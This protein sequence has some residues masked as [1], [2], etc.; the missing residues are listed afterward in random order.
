MCASTRPLRRHTSIQVAVF[1]NSIKTAHAPTTVSLSG[2]YR[3]PLNNSPPYQP[4]ISV[5]HIRP[6]AGHNY[7]AIKRWRGFDGTLF[8][9]L[10][11]SNC[12]SI[13]ESFLMEKYEKWYTPL[14]IFARSLSLSLINFFQVLSP[15]EICDSKRERREK[16]ISFYRKIALFRNRKVPLHLRYNK[17]LLFLYNYYYSSKYVCIRLIILNTWYRMRSSFSLNVMSVFLL[18]SSQEVLLWAS[19]DDQIAFN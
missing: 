18:R 17:N 7:L 1:F 13:V 12:H 16:K 10:A 9:K 15:D 8:R 5:M 2:Y 19:S 3:R 4:Q 11:C 14:K 6:S